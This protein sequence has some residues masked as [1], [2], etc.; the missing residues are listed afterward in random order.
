[1]PSQSD[2][3]GPIS[4][5]LP[6]TLCYLAVTIA[7]AL[8]VVA[9]SASGQD[10]KK[11]ESKSQ[12]DDSVRLHSDLVVL[13]VTVTDSSGGYAHG[14]TAK[15]FSILEDGTAQ[16]IDSFS[17][18]EAPF[19]AAILADMSGSME[20]KFG[21]VRGAAAAFIE[22]I[23]DDDQVALYGFNNKVRLFQDFTNNR[24]ITDYIWDVRA[25]DAT[26]LYDCLD[27]GIDALAKRPEKRRA[28]LLISD[29]WDSSS[30]KA[31][32]DSVL[33]KAHA[34]GVT[35][36]A[37]DLTDDRLLTG[38]ASYAAGLRRGR[39]EMQEFAGQ[40]GGRYVHS[41]VGDKLEEAFLNIVEE[42][43]NQYTLTYYSTND[44]RDGRFRKLL[45]NMSRPDLTPRY[46]KGYFAPKG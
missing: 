39:S 16:P 40:T 10:K 27:Q 33:K 31:S 24:Y 19:A 35:I 9:V 7:L 11:T 37:V 5:D 44:K 15:N 1:M 8:S 36:Y 42:L 12:Q 3:S 4:R 22:G 14:L 46:R 32:M 26:S 34:A 13:S 17:A 20:S 29:G 21:L 45:V 28:V 23:R 41:P 25:E 43:H 38:T 2:H 6:R 18:E 30:H